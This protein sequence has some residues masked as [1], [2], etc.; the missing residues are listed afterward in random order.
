MFESINNNDFKTIDIIINRFNFDIN[1][2]SDEF[3][4]SAL[5]SH[6]YEISKYLIYKCNLN[7]VYCNKYLIESLIEY[8]KN[9]DIYFQ[10][11]KDL[12]YKFDH[13]NHA[14]LYIVNFCNIQEKIHLIKYLI[15]NGCDVNTIDDDK[16]KEIE[17]YLRKDKIK[18]LCQQI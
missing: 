8:N 4:E 14:F 13:K 16:K 11:V 3:I 7:N 12:I 5:R 17:T 1:E 18:N 15:K 10:L 9:I 6:N 2:D